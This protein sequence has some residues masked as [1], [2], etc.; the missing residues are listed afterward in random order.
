MV[1]EST[2]PVTLNRTRYV[3][4]EL[5]R[6]M[7]GPLVP[8]A[9]VVLGG[10]LSYRVV[11]YGSAPPYGVITGAAGALAT[12]SGSAAWQLIL[13]LIAGLFSQRGF[14]QDRA[15]GRTPYILVR[16]VSRRAHFVARS[17]GPAAGAATVALCGSVLAL[18]FS[19]IY[20]P[21]GRMRFAEGAAGRGPVHS[22]FTEAPLVND[23][24]LV[25]LAMLSTWALSC[26]AGAAGTVTQRRP[27]IL[28]VPVLVVLAGLALPARL[29]ILSP[30]WNSDLTSSALTGGLAFVYW[31]SIGSAALCVGVYYASR[32]EL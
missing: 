18:L 3:F 12:T 15:L 24:C 5:S 31:L 32:Q 9:S 14:V 21:S 30:L 20:L 10:F 28:V 19:L 22:L 17:F 2:F 1:A 4:R 7:T 6:E 29:D 16:G 11:E 13:P 8:L 23:L 25:A 27:V 26:V